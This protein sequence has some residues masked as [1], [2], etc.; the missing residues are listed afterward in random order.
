MISYVRDSTLAGVSYVELRGFEPL[1]LA[2]EMPYDLQVRSVS[3]QFSPARYLR[4]CFRVLTAS[5][6]LIREL[7]MSAPTKIAARHQPPLVP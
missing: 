5:R 4:F 7:G 3:F 6:A 2:A 1:P